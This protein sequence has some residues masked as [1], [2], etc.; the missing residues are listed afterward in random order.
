[1]SDDARHHLQADRIDYDRD[2][3]DERTVA[4]DPCVQFERWFE[5]ARASAILDPGAMTLATVDADG[6]PSAR[7]VLLRG[8][9]AR[10][11]VFYSNYQ[12]RKGRALV[13][14]PEAALVWFWPPLERQ[15][16]IEGGVERISAVESDAYFSARPR[17]H[18]LAAWA[19]SQSAIVPD[20]AALEREFASAETRFAEREVERPPHWGGYRVRPR[21]FEFWQGRP[22]RIH[23]RIAYEEAPN[24]WRIERLAP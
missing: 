9:D 2:A 17:G 7:I 13:A 19:S 4:S 6:R 14:T 5:A 3:L 15:I 24:G 12:S 16:R 8:F 10:G 21:R 1:M 22:N 18:R 11:F 20:R 23:D